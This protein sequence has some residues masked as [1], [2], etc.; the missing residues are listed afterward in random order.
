MS[1]APGHSACLKSMSRIITMQD[2]TLRA[3]IAS[4]T[5]FNASFDANNARLHVNH[6]KVTQE[7]NLHLGQG[8]LMVI[9]RA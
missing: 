1:R 5:L 8:L 4:E 6:N 7:Q 3:I 2:L 9:V